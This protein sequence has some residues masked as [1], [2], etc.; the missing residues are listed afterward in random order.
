[1]TAKH[2]YQ[3]RKVKIARKDKPTRKDYNYLR[4]RV[5]V[6]SAQGDPFDF[7]KN[8]KH[9]KKSPQPRLTSS[10]QIGEETDTEQPAV[11]QLQS[12]NGVCIS[13]ALTLSTNMSDNQQNDSYNPSESR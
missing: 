7:S 12:S 6:R 8:E 9:N 11:I 4:F 13:Y 3:K 2:S 10:S 1:M 5:W